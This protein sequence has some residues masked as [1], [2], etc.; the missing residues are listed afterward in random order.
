YAKGENTATPRRCC[1]PAIRS[2]ARWRLQSTPSSRCAS[3]ARRAGA[4]SP[5]AR[6]VRGEFTNTGIV[7]LIINGAAGSICSLS[8]FGERVGVRGLQN[9]RET[10]TPHPTP[11]PTGALHIKFH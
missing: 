11:L 7:V 10:L 1:A 5:W 3:N 6:R 2:S 9:Y 8:P 4:T